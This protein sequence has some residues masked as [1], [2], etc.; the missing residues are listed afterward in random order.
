[1]FV[2]AEAVQGGRSLRRLPKLCIA[3]EPLSPRTTEGGCWEVLGP[4]GRTAQL[5]QLSVALA[6]MSSTISFLPIKKPSIRA[7]HPARSPP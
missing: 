2:T 5:K 7:P 4:R 6:F 3:K 1:V